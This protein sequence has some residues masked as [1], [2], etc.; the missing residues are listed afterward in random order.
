MKVRVDKDLCTGCGLCPDNV[1]E[2]FKMEGDAASTIRETVE[3]P[4][5]DKVK[6]AAN[7]CPVEAIALEEN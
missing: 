3:E 4:L 1:P 2:V 5:I 6:D 7:D